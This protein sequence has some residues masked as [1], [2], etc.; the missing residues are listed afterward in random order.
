MDRIHA[1]AINES[2]VSI[3]FAAALFAAPGK[4]MSAPPAEL[5]NMPGATLAHDKEQLKKIASLFDSAL[6][7][8]VNPEKLGEF[9]LE[10][11]QPAEMEKRYGLRAGSEGKCMHGGT[12]KLD[13][14]SPPMQPSSMHVLKFSDCVRD[15]AQAGNAAERLVIDGDLNVTPLGA[16]S[17][18]GAGFEAKFRK[19]S[20][21]LQSG[22]MTVLFPTLNGE[23]RCLSR[24]PEK[25]KEGPA[26]ACTFWDGKRFWLSADHAPV[27]DNVAK[28][29]TA[30]DGVGTILVSYHRSSIMETG[31]V[32]SGSQEGQTLKF[33]PCKKD[34]TF[35]VT[36]SAPG[37]ADTLIAKCG[38]L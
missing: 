38:E 29:R 16:T 31:I 8:N 6:Y 36:A 14:A 30:V 34:D 13:Y 2:A 12:G 32:V 21:G 5:L 11:L 9:V 1:A 3:L 28:F 24:P 27:S 20:L 23:L 4:A 26:H 19:L 25:R 7:N 15:E 37:G 10:L 35:R 22:H 18:G 17:D 33:T